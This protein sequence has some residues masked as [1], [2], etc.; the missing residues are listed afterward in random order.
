M[1]KE[2]IIKNFQSHKESKLE[3]SK[4]VNIIVGSSDSGKTAIL[5]ALRWL[6]WNRPSGDAFRSDW[7]GKTSV[8]LFTDDAHIVRSKDKEAEYVLGDTHFEAFRTDVPKEIQDA[9]NMSEI[10]FQQQLDSPFL[11]TDS[12]GEVAQHFNKVARLDK[13]D[14][15]LQNVQRSIRELEQD[16]KYK[17]NT[18][19]EQETTLESYAF[20]E[21]MEVDVEVLED[22]EKSLQ[23]KETRKE[24]L[25]DLIKDYK[26]SV[27]ELGEFENTIKLE[28]QVNQVL[29]FIDERTE[30]DMKEVKLER[31]VDKIKDVRDEIQEY[32]AVL[33]TEEQ[34]NDL[35]E[36]I[37]RRDEIATDYKSLQE[38]LIRLNKN[39]AI[40]KHKQE[41]LEVMQETFTKE[42]GSVCL[43]CGQPI[44]K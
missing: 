17:S 28:K 33:A 11:L 39:N 9:L 6:V 34:V 7:G 22:M 41:S 18:L 30:I 29:Q 35:L 5:R 3:F 38:D 20:L 15:G 23:G 13:I 10:N 16:I 40:I 1:F 31:L 24:R 42:M 19:T 37:E 25:S 36:L 43:L 32:E 26:F 14:S 12:P 2:L 8:E 4:G 44:K 27:V 21:K